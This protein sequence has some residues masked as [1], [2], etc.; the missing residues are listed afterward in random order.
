MAEMWGIAT[1]IND[2]VVSPMH[3]IGVKDI[4]DGCVSVV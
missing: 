2:G 3:R 1:A 4:M